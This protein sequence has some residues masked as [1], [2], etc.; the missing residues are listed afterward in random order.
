MAKNQAQK[1]KEMSCQCKLIS[2]DGSTDDDCVSL[3]RSL[4]GG[5]LVDVRSYFEYVAWIPKK[6]AVVG[7]WLRI[8]GMSGNWRV[9][10]IWA[11]Q[12]TASA[13]ERSRDYLRT[14]DASDV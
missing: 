11:T 6:K 8:D 10:E 12:Q 9:E 7:K 5:D 14:R 4:G 1:D 13:T 3:I 2:F